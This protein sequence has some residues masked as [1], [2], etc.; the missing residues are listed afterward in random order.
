MS[1]DAD[2]DCQLCH[3][4]GTR[5][6]AGH[7]FNPALGRPLVLV[8]CECRHAI[9]EERQRVYRAELD[10]RLDAHFELFAPAIKA[11]NAGFAATSNMSRPSPPAPLSSVPN[12]RCPR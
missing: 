1:D 2:P 6:V 3:G 11:I 10:A 9:I 5:M 8:W 4:Q 7:T 12:R